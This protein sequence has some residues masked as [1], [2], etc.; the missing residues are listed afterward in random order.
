MPK[1]QVFRGLLTSFNRTNVKAF[2]DNLSSVLNLEKFAAKDIYN[3]DETAVTTIEKPNMVVAKMGIRQVRALSSGEHGTLVTGIIAV[4]V[5][6]NYIPKRFIFARKRY[7]NYFIRDGPI[8]CIGT[9]NSSEWIK[10]NEFVMFHFQ[11]RI[12]S[13]VDGKVLF[14]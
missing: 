11:N 12:N 5:I 14:Y 9:G 13:F 3:I 1:L 2:Y 10:E 8:G 6:G 4:S 7:D